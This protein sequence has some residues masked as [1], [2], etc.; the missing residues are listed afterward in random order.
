MYCVFVLCVCVCMSVLCVFSVFRDTGRN[1]LSIVGAHPEGHRHPQ[2]HTQRPRRTTLR[3]FENKFYNVLV[4]KAT[5][6]TR[7]NK[8]PPQP[9]REEYLGRLIIGSPVARYSRP[10]G[11]HY[12]ATHSGMCQSMKP[13]IQVSIRQ[14]VI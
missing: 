10:D 7:R 5:H 13:A 3:A 14:V 11:T 6:N 9:L 4:E 12:G 2:I 8:I 1:F